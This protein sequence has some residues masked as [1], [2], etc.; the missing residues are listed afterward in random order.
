MDSTIR[1]TLW[2][3][4]AVL[5]LLVAIG[6]A[7]TVVIMQ[8]GKRQE[9]GIVHMSE[10]FL[11]A[12]QQMDQDVVAML[13]AARGYLLTQQTQF[14]QQYDEAVRDFAKQADVAMQLAGSPRDGQLIGQFRR[15]F[16]DLKGL[17]DQQIELM[18]QDKS[19]NA[20]EYMLE[21]ARLRRSAPD[22]YGTLADQHRRQENEQ[23]EEVSGLRQG[24]TLLMVI[25]SAVIIVLG[26]YTMWRIQ[27]S[28]RA[29]IARE[30]RR[31]EAMIAGMSDGIML[32]DRDG[33]SVFINPAGQ[34]LLGQS[35]IGVHH[36]TGR[37][38]SDQ[39]RGWA[40]SGS[41]GAAG[42]TGAVHGQVG[43]RCDAARRERGR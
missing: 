38:V 24:L 11:D 13:G 12:V 22:F 8:T 29:S 15:H 3:A 36:R 30:V 23:L 28:L 16:A 39:E 1:R 41:E 43:R 35:Q 6:L 34:K 31:T 5:S 20:N 21:A 18:K 14:L 17:T 32:I 10:P 37:G 19:G 9:Y 2:G 40:E 26:A 7:L 27:Q 25:V 4:F 42:R 33:K